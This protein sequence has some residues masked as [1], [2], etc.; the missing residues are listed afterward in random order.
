MTI[1]QQVRTAIRDAVNRKSRKPFHWGGLR[2]YQQLAV[3]GEALGS[4]PVQ[5]ETVYLQQLA[6]QVN[7]ALERSRVL[8]ADLTE[9]H[10]WLRRVA[11]C[12]HYPYRSASP[13]D[14]ADPTPSSTQVRAEMESL[15]AAFQPDLKR[16]EAQRAL[17]NAWHRLW[18][19]WGPHLL[20][21][22]DIPGLPADNL[23]LERLFGKLR[24]HQRRISGQKSTRPLRDFG[25]YQVLFAAES[26]A[27]LL[28]QLRQVPADTY[29][30]HRQRLAQAEV[31]RQ[32]SY[33][34]HRDP[35]GYIQRLIDQ[36]TKRRTMLELGTDPVETQ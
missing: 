24:C 18:R 12:L 9:A 11:D 17:F 36:H 28:E 30:Q 15:L 10:S 1:E 6:L 34:L 29:Q 26:E 32:Q 13:P 25:Q 20:H 23:E 5:A 19:S 4:V 14:A 31:P 2:G 27:E 21:C 22:Y 3:I 35:A 33:R 16:R 7:R 8:A